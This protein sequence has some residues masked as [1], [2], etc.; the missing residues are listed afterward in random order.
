MDLSCG[1]IVVDRVTICWQAGQFA[2]M[3]G[4]LDLGTVGCADGGQVLVVLCQYRVSKARLPTLLVMV[5]SIN[6]LPFSS[7][8]LQP[9]A[10]ASLMGL[11]LYG[12][13]TGT[14]YHKNKPSWILVETAV[15]RG[16]IPASWTEKFH[17]S[18]F[19]NFRGHC[20]F[21]HLLVPREVLLR[22][23]WCRCSIVFV[24]SVI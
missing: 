7:I 10:Q 14:R 9:Q 3:V 11:S 2:L 23:I 18:F 20:L 16:S 8:V 4:G 6:R 22:G 19:C 15:L 12:M 17:P 1:Q 21:Q 13:R 24:S 5:I